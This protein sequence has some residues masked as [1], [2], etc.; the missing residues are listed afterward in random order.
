MPVIAGCLTRQSPRDPVGI[1]EANQPGP[2]WRVQR[3]GID[4]AVG[5]ALV[6]ADL[7]DAELDPVASLEPMDA[8]VETEKKLQ[9]VPVLLIHII[10]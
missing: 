2:V 8:A 7:S 3:Q 6:A 9:P 10:S 1:V 4:Q 5:P